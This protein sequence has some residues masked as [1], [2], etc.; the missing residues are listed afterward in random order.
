MPGR[1]AGWPVR[2]AV[3]LNPKERGSREQAKPRRKRVGADGSSE[4]RQGRRGTGWLAER[5]GGRP[6]AALAPERE[7]WSWARVPRDL[8]G[9]AAEQSCGEVAASG[10]RKRRKARKNRRAFLGRAGVRGWG[11][12]APETR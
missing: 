11:P 9:G 1:W 7:G 8:W 6:P 3:R 12:E 10:S 5:M 2:A 4:K